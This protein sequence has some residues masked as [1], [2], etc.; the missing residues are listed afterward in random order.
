MSRESWILKEGAVIGSPMQ[1]DAWER[2]TGQLA[3][4]SEMSAPVKAELQEL[5]ESASTR[6]AAWLRAYAAY[7]QSL[8]QERIAGW[9]APW[10][11]ATPSSPLESFGP[12]QW[13]WRGGKAVMMMVVVI[14]A[15]V[16]VMVRADDADDDV[17]DACD[18]DGGEEVEMMADF[19]PA[20]RTATADIPSIGSA[21]STEFKGLRKLLREGPLKLTDLTEAPEK[22]FGAHRVLSEYATKVQF[23]LFAGTILALGNTQQA[24]GQLGCF[25]LTEKLAGVNSG[26][27]VNTTCTWDEEKRG[28]DSNLLWDLAVV[29][30][31]LIIK[32]QRKGPHGF[33]M[34]L[35]HAWVVTDLRNGE[36]VPGVTAQDMGDKTIGNDLDNAQIGFSKVWLPKDSLLDKYAGL[37]AGAEAVGRP[38]VWHQH[39]YFMSDSANALWA[40]HGLL[41]SFDVHIR[42]G[43][44]NM[45]MIG[46]RL[47]TGRHVIAM[48]TLVFARTLYK[49]AREYADKKMP[50][51]GLHRVACH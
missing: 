4:P 51:V 48:S 41:V 20:F 16:F 11:D 34:Q 18:D 26:L 43:I 23:N 1:R 7:E 36:L 27:V 9:P 15:M 50:G 32:G 49:S 21:R 30:A 28:L 44:T 10:A 3:G 24:K 39:I 38:G 45:D 33:I 2:S 35:R 46:Q 19:E 22:F 25:C 31:N 14:L 12:R 13:T 37:E 8:V 42:Q 6:T 5:K 29:V 17:D 47:Y 40:L